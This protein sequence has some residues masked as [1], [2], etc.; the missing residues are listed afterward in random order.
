MSTPQKCR[1]H[2]SLITVTVLLFLSPFSSNAAVGDFLFQWGAE[3]SLD[4][5]LDLAVD[6]S[7]NVYVADSGNNQIQVFDSSGPLIRKWGS[8]GI[9]EG[10]FD[11]PSGIAVDATGNV[12]VADSWNNRIQV[13][14]STGTF[15]TEWGSYGWEN[16]EFC[17]PTRIAVNAGGNV[18]YVADTGNHR[19]QVFDNLGTFITKWEGSGSGD[20]QFSYPYGIAVDATGNV[21]VADSGYHGIQI[22][23]NSGAFITKWGSCCSGDGQ[24]Y[25]PRGIAVDA[26]GN[27]YVADTYND[28]IQ[29]FEGL[30]VDSDG[31]GDGIPD[32]QDSCPHEDATGFDADSD[33]CIDTLGGLKAL[34]DTLVNEGVI[35]PELKTSLLTK[36]ENSHKSATKKN[37]YAAVNELKAF[38]NQINAQRGEKIT[39]E[40]ADLLTAYADNVI[41]SLLNE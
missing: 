19:I 20:G 31:D 16:G 13:F 28:R 8:D 15:K 6:G 25:N 38:Q 37:I 1:L 23:D 11:H 36:V 39:N 26:G 24:F 35:S 14:T 2:L 27:V 7:G 33:G 34:V 9:G 5:P 17:N 22:F 40:A 21:Y 4:S 3:Y 29:V 30:I 18:V 41:A 10:Q 32:D 12:Y